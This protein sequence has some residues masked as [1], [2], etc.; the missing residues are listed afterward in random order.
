MIWSRFDSAFVSILSA[1][2]SAFEFF[3]HCQIKNPTPA[4]AA[5]KTAP[6]KIKAICSMVNYTI[7]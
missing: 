3:C 6:K 7:K 4:T 1:L 2:D 5:P